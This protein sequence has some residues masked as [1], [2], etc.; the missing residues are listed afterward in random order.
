MQFSLGVDPNGEPEAPTIAGMSSEARVTIVM[1]TFERPML[2][3]RALSSVTHQSYR[4]WQLI[5]VNNGGEPGPVDAAVATAMR[6][7]AGGESKMRVLHTGERLGMETATNAALRDAGSSEFFVVHDDDDSWL[8]DFLTVAV[9]EMDKRPDAGAIVT[10]L[11]RITETLQ[12]N[13][14]WPVV[15]EEFFLSE[16]R[17]TFRGIIAGNTFPPIAALFRTRLLSEV[18]YFDESLPVLGDWEFNIRAVQH[19]PFVYVPQRLAKYHIR[20]PESDGN[21][22]NSITAGLATHRSVRLQLQDRWL[23]DTTS[24]PNLG[25]ISMLASVERDLDEMKRRRSSIDDSSA[26]EIA[27]AMKSQSMSRKILRG[28]RN[29]RHGIRAI[30]RRVDG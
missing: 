14:L 27:K 17:L 29:P 4:N 26:V 9:T 28:L 5:V 25:L 7:I 20:T 19:A 13:R 12:G 30:K 3:A 16:G 10:G 1:R 22:A 21:S 24:S 23:R 6:T 2:L 8:P 18:G 11:Y 15:E